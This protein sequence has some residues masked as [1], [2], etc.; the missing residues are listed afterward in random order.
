MNNSLQNTDTETATPLCDQAMIFAAGLGTRL[1]PLT[2]HM[3]KALVEVDGRPLIDRVITRLRD[4]GFKHLVVNVHH[5]SGQII[6]YLSKHDYSIDV[7]IS[8]ET[9]KLLDTGGGLRKA[10][11]L[12]DRNKPILIHNVDILSN[13]DLRA[14]CD[15][16]PRMR[17]YGTGGWLQASATLLVSWRKTKRYLLFDK[18]MRL[19]GWTNIETGEVRSPYRWLR[20]FGSENPDEFK[21][22]TE[23]HDNIT[24]RHRLLGYGEAHLQAYAFSGIHCIEPQLIDRMAKY[25]DIFPIMNFYLDNCSTSLIKGY[26]ADDLKLLD[27]GKLDTLHEADKF[28]KDL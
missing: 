18:D 12:F 24:V 25:P 22:L 5:F 28:V 2:D 26:A 8:D 20:E 14:F 10:A 16:A 7:R 6:D 13:A 9:D 21:T 11:A 15:E 27:V 23:H 1:K 4:F 19:V 3:P 17:N